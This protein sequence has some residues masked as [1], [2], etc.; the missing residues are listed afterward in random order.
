MENTTPTSTSTSTAATVQHVTKA[1]SDQ[2]L[3]KFAALDSPEQTKRSLKRQ[4]RA[5]HSLSPPVVSNTTT[6]RNRRESSEFGGSSTLVVER[7]SL[8][9]P[10]RRSSALV[11]IGKAHFRSRNFRNRSFFGTLGKTWR[12][13]VDGASNI[14]MEKQY[15]RH[16]RLLSDT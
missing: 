2:L 16:K 12:R 3:N 5:L 14:F 6:S 4:K 7:K 8:L 9:L 10:V 11:R 15:N 13:T 1:S